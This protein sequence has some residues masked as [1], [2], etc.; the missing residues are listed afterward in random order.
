MGPTAAK[1]NIIS[2]LWTCVNISAL[3]LLT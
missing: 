3:W 2:D 1:K